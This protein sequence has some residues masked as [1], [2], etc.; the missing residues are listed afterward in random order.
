MKSTPFSSH[1]PLEKG[2]MKL[3]RDFIN[4]WLQDPLVYCNNCG[5]PHFVGGPCCDDP[6]VGTNLQHCWAVI[7]QNKARQKLRAN[8]YGSNPGKTLRLGASLPEKLIRDLE[9]Y[10]R[11]HHQQKLWN[12]QKEFRLFLK[13]FPQFTICE[14][15]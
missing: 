5:M 13:S 2:K 9:L 15:I 3:I 8:E 12:N 11:E 6:C 1:Q 10:F 7:V 14:R 4:K